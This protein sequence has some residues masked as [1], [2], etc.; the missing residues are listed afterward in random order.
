M[1]TLHTV[2]HSGWE[3]WDADYFYDS[4]KK[5][6]LPYNDIHGQLRRPQNWLE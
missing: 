2:W 5:L 1:T 3:E 6:H 4:K